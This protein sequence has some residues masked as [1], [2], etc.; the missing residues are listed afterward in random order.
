MDNH[1][2]LLIET[3]QPNLSFGMRPLNG[4]YT[5]AYNRQHKRVGYLS[6]GRFTAILVGKEPQLL[7]L[8]RYVVLNPVR[9]K[10]VTH[11]RLWAWSSYLATVGETTAPASLTTDWTLGQFGSRVGS[12]QE[13][14]RTS[15]AE[16]PD[17]PR[18]WDQLTG[19]TYLGSENFIAQHQPDRVIRDTPRRL[20]QASR[21]TLPVLFQRRQPEARLIFDA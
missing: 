20:T 4:R 18:P 21:P 9:T 12:V 5:Q 15:E 13:Q 14:Y 7:E 6:Q 16:G 3:P 2:H 17:G 19:Q 1:H 11:P 10:T 8:C